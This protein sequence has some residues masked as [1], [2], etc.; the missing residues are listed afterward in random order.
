V[1]YQ[2]TV[3]VGADPVWITGHVANITAFPIE[4]NF[5]ECGEFKEINVFGVNT[6]ATP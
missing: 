6:G 4:Y 1:A 2:V 5:S 3:F